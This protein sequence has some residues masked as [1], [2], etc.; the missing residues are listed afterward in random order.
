MSRNITLDGNEVNQE[1]KCYV[2]A[3]IGHNHQGDVEK[4]KKLFDEAK[5]SGAN[6]VKI[7]K[8][9]NKE[10]FTQDMYDSPYLSLN[11]YGA[12]YG[13]HRD[14]L[15]FDLSQYKELKD[16]ASSIGITFFSTAFDF[17]SIEFLE[18]V[19][20]PI[21][22]V[23][24]GDIINTPLLKEIAKLNKPMIISTGGAS[25]DDVKRAYETIMPINNQLCIMQ[26]TSGYPPS[27]E[28]LN[29]NVIKTYMDE[30]NDIIIGFSAHDSGIA[31][32]LVG[33]VLGARIIEKHFTLNRALKG[34][35]HAFSLE[36]NGLK[37]LIRDLDR[38][39]TAF[40]DGNKYRFSSE[41][42]PLY[43][44]GKKIV[45]SRNLSSEH[46]ITFEDLSFKSPNDGLPPWEYIRVI[47]KKLK[48][49]INKDQNIELENLK[50]N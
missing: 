14:F 1:S 17:K 39:H 28:E 29:L 22:K 49:E 35:D 45:A 23:A 3:E 48:N 6:A 2:I 42:A 36:P 37:K 31:M 7:Q 21:Y 8:R 33:Y 40:G 44:M 43:K 32:G 4:C 16:Y 12:T 15:E 24:S 25:M 19:D 30:F 27:F 11:S 38:T 41:E 46:I 10:L 26:C 5:L 20:L 13:T 9:N 47:G 34:T 50:D 18:K